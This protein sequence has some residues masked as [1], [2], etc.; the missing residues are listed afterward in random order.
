VHV[1]FSICTISTSVGGQQQLYPSAA[2]H[3]LG[4]CHKTPPPRQPA[5]PHSSALFRTLPLTSSPPLDKSSRGFLMENSAD[6]GCVTA[7]KNVREPELIDSAHFG[8]ATHSLG[9]GLDILPHRSPASSTTLVNRSLPQSSLS[10]SSPMPHAANH[11]GSTGDRGNRRQELSRPHRALNERLGHSTSE[12]DTSIQIPHK[13]PVNGFSQLT[14]PLSYSSLSSVDSQ[15]PYANSAHLLYP[16]EAT[17]TA[18][19]PDSPES[20]SALAVDIRRHAASLH[21]APRPHPKLVARS[22]SCSLAK[23]P[24]RQ[25]SFVDASSYESVPDSPAKNVHPHL[26]PF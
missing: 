5:F 20:I 22:F 24:T 14:P 26:S 13:K 19:L 6:T 12:P 3:V 18:K 16:H 17:S 10:S 7:A 11:N 4:D 2:E 15:N 25:A 1:Q 8:G 23:P 9:L 21:S